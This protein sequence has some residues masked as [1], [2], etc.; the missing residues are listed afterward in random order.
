MRVII[1]SEP[2]IGACELVQQAM[3]E[4][5]IERDLEQKAGLR[6]PLHGM[7]CRVMTFLADAG[8]FLRRR[9]VNTV[10]WYSN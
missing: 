9:A 2:G 6:L 1:T 8:P 3:G 7:R 5:R 4:F 10:G